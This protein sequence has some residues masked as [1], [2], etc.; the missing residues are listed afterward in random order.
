[1][2]KMVATVE[3]P[4]FMA[5]SMVEQHHQRDTAKDKIHQPFYFRAANYLTKEEGLCDLPGT[6]FCIIIN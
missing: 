6:S 5:K 1:M 3:I 4:S 2:G